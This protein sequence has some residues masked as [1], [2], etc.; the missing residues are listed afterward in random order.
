VIY[1]DDYTTQSVVD[2]YGDIQKP[3]T[4]SH[5]LGHVL[6]LPDLY[7]RSQGVLAEQRRWVVGCWSLMAAGS[8][9]GCG[10]G[11]IPWLR[12]SHMG[13]WEKDRLGWLSH[14]EEVMD[15]LG[16]EFV[17]EPVRTSEH[18]LKVPLENDIQSD[19][20]EYLLLEYRTREGF[21]ENLPA[22]G[23]LVY[24]IDPKVSGNQPCETCQQVYRV[25]LLEADG[26]DG[27]RRNTLQ[28]GNRGEAGDAWGVT[29]PGR[30][31]NT[32]Y[33]STQLHSGADSPVTIYDISIVDGLAHITLSSRAI[34]WTSLIQDFL[35]TGAPPLT[36]Q[37]REYLDE[38]GN[39]NGQYDVGDLRAYMRR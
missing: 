17:L 12:P 8:G 26:N 37:E 3:T 31:T 29:G 20:M 33:P 35:G 13:P 6:G 38:R 7:D 27:L 25:S 5:E 1:V 24:H 16:E 30:L 15:A 22:S 34:P 21:D 23:V 10:T 39:G 9:W 14:R 11:E 36:S 28:G 2:C 18:V 32:T 19:S 4:I